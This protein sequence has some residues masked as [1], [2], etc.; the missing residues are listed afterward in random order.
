MTDERIRVWSFLRWDRK[1]RAA[2]RDHAA[3]P[4]YEDAPFP[5]RIRSEAD[6]E[7]G[8]P[9]RMLAWEDPFD[10]DGPASPF[11]TD[12]PMLS[13]EGSADA[14]PLLPMLAEAGARIEG[15][16]LGD[17]GLILKV[18]NH[19]MA[20]QVHMADDRLLMDGGGVRLPH[21]WGPEIP[22]AIARL[23][24]LWAVS[25]GPVPRPGRVRGAKTGS[26]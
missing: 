24:D 22:A 9:W 23:T 14:P 17:G 25:G 1:Y 21:Y 2:W 19:G 6:L 11:W 15:L 12:A 18:E 10:E 13:G 26:C 8:Q 16:R 5:V 3:P 7:A 4:E 20:A